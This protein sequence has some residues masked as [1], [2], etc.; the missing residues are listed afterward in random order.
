VAETRDH[1]CDC[2]SGIRFPT[3]AELRLNASA[4]L[5][6]K[7]SRVARNSIRPTYAKR[8]DKIVADGCGCGRPS[9]KQ[10]GQMWKEALLGGRDDFFAAS[11]RSVVFALTTTP[12]VLSSSAHLGW[13]RG[14]G[15]K[16]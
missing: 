14:D 9:T 8:T 16:R 13:E 2:A 10:L 15:E 3:N 12:P 7:L 1:A 5:G 6:T 11:P 4:K